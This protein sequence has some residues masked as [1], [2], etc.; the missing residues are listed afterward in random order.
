MRGQS[1]WYLIIK[2]LWLKWGQI[3]GDNFRL[4]FSSSSSSSPTDETSEGKNS[5]KLLMRWDALQNFSLFSV[6]TDPEGF[7]FWAASPWTIL[8]NA[9]FVHSKKIHPKWIITLFA[10]ETNKLPLKGVLI[11]RFKIPTGCPRNNIPCN[12]L[13]TVCF[14]NLIAL[15]HPVY[16]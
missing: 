8:G 7:F 13:N 14:Y 16:A 11:Y 15:K 10:Y 12:N 4:S 6:L 1:W 5:V 9:Q 3:W 2:V